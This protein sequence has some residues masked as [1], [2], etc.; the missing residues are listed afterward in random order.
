MGLKFIGLNVSAPAELAACEIGGV[1]QREFQKGGGAGVDVVV[2]RGDLRNPQQ[3]WN[4]VR[5]KRDIDAL[6]NYNVRR[7]HTV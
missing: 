4:N 6:R 7:S 2:P 3:L 1:L 5:C